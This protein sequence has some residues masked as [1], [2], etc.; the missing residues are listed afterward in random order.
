MSRKIAVN[1]GYLWRVSVKVTFSLLCAGA[2]YSVWLG[3]FLLSAK[4]GS[5]VV[6]IIGWLL[7]PAATAIGFAAGVVIF[8][9]LTKTSKTKFFRIFIWSLFGCAV[10]AGA[11]YWFGPMLIVFGMFV[12]GAA[13]V[14]FREMVP[15]IRKKDETQRNND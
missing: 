15:I 2:F 5:S 11:V 12:A 3:A 8:E 13:S 6:D 14:A 7:S 4:L 9:H 10:G 1:L